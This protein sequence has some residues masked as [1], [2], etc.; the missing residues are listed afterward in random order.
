MR[1]TTRDDLAYLALYGWIPVIVIMF[2]LL[3]N[4]L[5]ATTAVI[6]A[7]LILPP[8]SMP[9]AGLP[10]YSKS[11]AAVFG[12]LLGTFFCCPDRIL[13]FRPRWFDLPMA[14]WCLSGIVSSLQNGLG[15]YDGLASSLTLSVVWGLPYFVRL[16]HFGDFDRLRFSPSG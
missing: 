9:M 3:P 7:W 12:V 14:L 15:L 5:A 8:Y 6:G 16:L 13:T 4:R 1:N 2:A 11:T 10:D